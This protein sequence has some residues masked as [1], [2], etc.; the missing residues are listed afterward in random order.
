M[1]DSVELAKAFQSLA[2]T[3]PATAA[4]LQAFLESPD[5]AYAL[6]GLVNDYGLDAPDDVQ[7]RFRAAIET[8]RPY[9]AERSLERVVEEVGRARPQL[10]T[11]DREEA[12]VKVIK[13]TVENLITAT[14]ERIEKRVQSLDEKIGKRVQSLALRADLEDAVSLLRSEVSELKEELK[15]VQERISDEVTRGAVA[16]CSE[17]IREALNSARTGNKGWESV[18]KAFSERLHPH[19]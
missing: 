12:S 10:Q 18:L 19:S 5:D 13:D 4:S 9:A 3:D 17:R 14:D 1:N 2:K 15:R 7:K 8:I 11:Y 6:A 16:A